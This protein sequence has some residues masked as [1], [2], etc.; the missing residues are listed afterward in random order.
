VTR[1]MVSF[2]NC[3][4]NINEFEIQMY[5]EIKQNTVMKIALV[6]VVAVAPHHICSRFGK[7]GSLTSSLRNLITAQYPSTFDHVS[8]STSRKQ[9]LPSYN[10][11]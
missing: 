11:P 6:H 4:D 1:P 7:H 9:A 8:C 5:I 10:L 3:I 2:A